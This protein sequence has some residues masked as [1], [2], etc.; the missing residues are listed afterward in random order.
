MKTK[1]ISHKQRPLAAALQYAFW[2]AAL[3]P[4]FAMAQT[5]PGG[6]TN[7]PAFMVGEKCADLIKGQS[8]PRAE[9]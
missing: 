8:L 2:S 4:T 9:L 6:N 3:L 5:V 1:K 7:L